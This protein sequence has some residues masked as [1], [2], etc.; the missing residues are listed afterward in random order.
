M[1]PSRECGGP[2]EVR[3]FPV[4]IQADRLHIPRQI[5]YQLDLVGLPLLGEEIHASFLETSRRTKGRSRETISFM[6]SSIF[7]RSSGVKVVS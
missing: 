5:I 7:L 6:R 3:E 4:G 1:T 2:A